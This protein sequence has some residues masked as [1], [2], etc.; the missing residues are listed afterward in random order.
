M[1]D[2]NFKTVFHAGKKKPNSEKQLNFDT[3]E[4]GN[5]KGYVMCLWPASNRM[6]AYRVLPWPLRLDKP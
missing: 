6:H 3:L 5:C 1:E 2:G 4:C